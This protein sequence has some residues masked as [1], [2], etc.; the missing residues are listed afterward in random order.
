MIKKA[1]LMLKNN[2]NNNNNII[3]NKDL[4]NW[5]SWEEQLVHFVMRHL[6]LMLHS[7]FFFVK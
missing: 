6:I 4:L 2:D 1:D 3:Y 7:F 5:K